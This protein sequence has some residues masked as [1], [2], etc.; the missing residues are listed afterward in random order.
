MRTQDL[1]RPRI[2]V[3]ILAELARQKKTQVWLINATGIKKSTLRSRLQGVRPFYVHELT[4][5]SAALGVRLST[6]VE[7]SDLPGDDTQGGTR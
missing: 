1:R 2:A 5:I 6:L 4:K 7:R 3:E